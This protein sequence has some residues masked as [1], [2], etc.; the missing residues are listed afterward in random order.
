MSRTSTPSPMKTYHSTSGDYFASLANISKRVYPLNLQKFKSVEKSK[1][2]SPP[3]EQMPEFI[4]E[5]VKDVVQSSS[6]RHIKSSINHKRSVSYNY[7]LVNKQDPKP[8]ST[9]Y[10]GIPQLSYKDFK[11]THK[12]PYNNE[13][14]SIPQVIQLTKRSKIILNSSKPITI[15]PSIYHSRK[16]SA[17]QKSPYIDKKPES[18][19]SNSD[20][21]SILAPGLTY[22]EKILRLKA[23]VANSIF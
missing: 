11:N 20:L 8:Q 4:K 1:K 10:S 16:N 14:Y 23:I 19:E 6:I 17:P 13:R 21:S 15:N 22:G 9:H 3:K 7:S 18:S 5:Y 2:I 12:N